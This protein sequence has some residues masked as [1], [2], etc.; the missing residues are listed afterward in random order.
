M[1][2]PME[3]ALLWARE[4]K[5]RPDNTS[6]PADDVCAMAIIRYLSTGGS[7]MIQNGAVEIST[8]EYGRELISGE[9]LLDCLVVAATRTLDAWDRA[10]ADADVGC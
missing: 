7:V 5:T 2:Q 10:K 6:T 3:L 9:S 1:T 8:F 4:P